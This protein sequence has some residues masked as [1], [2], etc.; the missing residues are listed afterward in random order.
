MESA[1]HG[2]SLDS[3][4]ELTH[5]QNSIERAMVNFE[6]TYSKYTD[7]D[8]SIYIDEDDDLKLNLNFKAMPITQLTGLLSE[9]E[10]IRKQYKKVNHRN[11]KKDIEHLDKHAMHIIR[12][13]LTGTEL[14]ETGKMCTYRENDIDLLM[15]I[16]NGHFRN[17]DGTYNSAYYD[18]KVDLDKKFEYAKEHTV[19]SAKPNY[20]WI[21]EFVVK[22]NYQI[23]QGRC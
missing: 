21:E 20:E 8:V 5:L 17:Y 22:T 12:L 9:F 18:L 13:L 1:I 23:I 15:A 2:E 14:L 7:G 19:L 10:N 16:R 6:S 3:L 11:K 4:K